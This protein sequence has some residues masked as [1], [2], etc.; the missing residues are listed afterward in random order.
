MRKSKPL[1]TEFK[2][3]V[4]GLTGVMLWL[5]IQEGKERMRKLKCN[6]L[7]GTVACVVRGV[8]NISRFRHQSSEHSDNVNILNDTQTPYLY[9]GDS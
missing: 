9:F 5:E 4:N 2:N 6:E 7:G 8:E 1:G 3:I